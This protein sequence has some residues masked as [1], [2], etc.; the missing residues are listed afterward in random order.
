MICISYCSSATDMES[1]LTSCFDLNDTWLIYIASQAAIYWLL[2]RVHWLANFRARLTN[3]H[4]RDWHIAARGARRLE[5]SLLNAAAKPAY[6]AYCVICL[7][8]YTSSQLIV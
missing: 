1:I 5:F 8:A 7:H 2:F 4:C 6:G 3:G